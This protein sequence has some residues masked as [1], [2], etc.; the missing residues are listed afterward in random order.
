MIKYGSFEEQLKDLEKLTE[1]KQL[2]LAFSVAI[3]H[4]KGEMAQVNKGVYQGG[5]FRIFMSDDN[6]CIFIVNKTTKIVKATT[7]ANA[8]EWE[9]LVEPRT[10]PESSK[11]K[12]KKV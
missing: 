5:D 4:N 6:S 7:L 1:L 8:R 2:R 11:A 10:M 9:F 3:G 12:V